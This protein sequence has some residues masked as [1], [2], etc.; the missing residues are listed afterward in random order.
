MKSRILPS[1]IMNQIRSG[2][3]S[4]QGDSINFQEDQTINLNVHELNLTDESIVRLL[5]QIEHD[6]KKLRFR[7]TPNIPVAY[8]EPKLTSRYKILGKL[9]VPF[10]VL[11][12]RLFTKWYSDTFSNQQKHFNNDAWYGLN[13]IIQLV[14]K[15]N[16]LLKTVVQENEKLR[17]K[18]NHIENDNKKIDLERERLTAQF[19]GL[20]QKNEDTKE[21][22]LLLTN[23][24]D[25][26]DNSFLFNYS[27]F[28]ERFGSDSDSVKRVFSQYIRYIDKDKT[29]TDIGC[30]K[31]YF[32]ELLK[33]HGITGKG[34]DSDPALIEICKQKGFAAETA[35]AISY[36]E[37][38]P[39]NSVEAIFIGHIIEHFPI[40]LKIKFIQ[41]A[42]KKLAYGGILILET[43]NTTSPYVMHNLY[44][45]DP[46][47]QLPM[48]PET[49]KHLFAE[50]NFSIIQSYLS[51]EIPQATSEYYNYSLIV[52]KD[53]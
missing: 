4:S 19:L 52:R 6:S 53:K 28:A 42:Y 36:L 49:Y 24:V 43:P 51:Y 39:N 3:R 11:G 44:Y 30:G 25:Q 2:V 48:F 32:L 26:L 18:L 31:G 47:H 5:E 40:H 17:N 35:D 41:T 12:T 22:L 8:T 16:I 1:E 14:D 34:V 37:L 27:R 10:R 21:R 15:Q 38:Q 7:I 33:E 29:V 46:T 45:L 20:K 23:K 9:L 50:N 13:A